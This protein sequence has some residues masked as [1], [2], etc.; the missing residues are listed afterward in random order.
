VNL[1]PSPRPRDIYSLVASLV[2]TAI[3]KEANASVASYRNIT[4]H[5]SSAVREESSPLPLAVLLAGKVHYRDIFKR[6][7]M[8]SV[9]GVTRYTARKQIAEALRDMIH[10]NITFLPADRLREMS[11]Y[12]TVK[13]FDSMGEVFKRAAGI[14]KWLIDC[15]LEIGKSVPPPPLQPPSSPDKEEGGLTHRVYPSTFLTWKTPLGFQVTQPY[16]MRHSSTQHR[17][18]EMGRCQ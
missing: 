6:P 9:Y 15:A 18:G 16:V 2:S 4:T 3:E 1:S 12:L 8:T 11:Q 7:V 13:T 17:T 14:Q 5:N 10:Q